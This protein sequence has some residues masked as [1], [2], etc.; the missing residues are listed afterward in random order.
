VG[1]TKK[2]KLAASPLQAPSQSVIAG[3]SFVEVL[4]STHGVEA[5]APELKVSS[6]SLLDLFP[7]QSCFETRSADELR[8]AMDCSALERLPWPQAAADAALCSKKKKGN[9][10][11]SGLLRNLG[12]I[13]AKLDWVLVGYGSRF[14]VC[15]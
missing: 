13:H 9:L 1:Q 4:Q 14:Q 3:R 12:Q 7:V 15:P 6:S 2:T 10:G 11:I 8:S 5:K